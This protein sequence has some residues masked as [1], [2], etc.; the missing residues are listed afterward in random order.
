MAVIGLPAT[1]DEEVEAVMVLKPGTALDEH[2]SW[3]KLASGSAT[4]RS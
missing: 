1:N 3:R 4:S 2:Q